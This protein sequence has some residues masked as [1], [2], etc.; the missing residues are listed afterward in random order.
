M[1]PVTLDF[2]TYP[3]AKRPDYPP[4]PVSLALHLPGMAPFS[5]LWGHPSGNNCTEAEAREWL[6]K[7]WASKHPVLCHNAKFDLSVACEGMGFL[8]LP[9]RRIHDTMILAFLNDPHA[10][11]LGLKGLAESLLG[12]PPTEQDAVKE[13]VWAN[14]AALAQRYGGKAPTKAKAGAW[15]Y[16]VPGEVVAPYVLGDVTR[17][18]ALFDRLLPRIE[19]LGMGD[20]YN[21][22][23]Q[24]M[25]ILME[26]ERDGIRVDVA[27]L[28]HDVKGYTSHFDYTEAWLRSALKAEGL[29][30]D[31]D[32]DVASVLLSAGIVKERDFPRT[33]PTKRHPDGQR[34][35]AKDSLTPDLFTGPRGALIASMLGYRNRLK[36]CLSMFMGPWLAQANINGGRITTNWHQTRGASFG[37]T[38]TGRPSTS[39]FNFLNISKSFEGRNDGFVH[40][41]GLPA[42]P[43]C[44]QYILPDE[45]E[46]F[47]HRDFSGQELRVF[48]HFEQGDLW[49]QYQAD[50]H[51]DPHQFVGDELRRVSGQELPRMSVK[52]LNFQSL[53]GGGV[54]A[55]Q[56]T[57]RCTMAEARNLKDFHNR[58]LP[59]RR[60]LNEEITRIVRRG[61][62]IRTWGGRLYRPE[63]PGPDGRD[64]IYKLI[65]YLVQ[66][67]AA[68]L[69]KQVMVDWYNHPDRKARLLTAVYDELDISVAP[70][71]VPAQMRLL[72][73]VMAEERLSV[74]MRSDGKTGPSWGD[75]TKWT[76]Q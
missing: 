12:E 14:R 32:Q 11:T 45:G 69:T 19:A 8:M 67:S 20:A 38:R 37:G 60:I 75:L 62:S 23:R 40:P 42:L 64:K 30:F 2:E 1:E 13:W 51:T 54:P 44:R 72:R 43:L 10:R 7:V 55:L 29:N 17:T 47:I 5:L 27:R 4:K 58:A 57:L 24:L 39:D 56:R 48:A 63:R 66:G 70:D 15:I 73:D 9:W 68:D 65:N 61:D 76:D 50:P 25:P 53:Y 59:G 18:R 35:V 34:S 3:I 33:K 49:R 28:H 41:K 36:T 22:E 31:A 52:I 16:A 46:V 21:R 71:A 6:A 26:N 74:P